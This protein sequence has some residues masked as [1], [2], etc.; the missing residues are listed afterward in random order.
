MDDPCCQDE[1]QFSRLCTVPPFSD[2]QCVSPVIVSFLREFRLSHLKKLV[3]Q[4]D[5]DPRDLEEWLPEGGGEG[6]H[7]D[8]ERIEA[9]EEVLSSLELCQG[10]PW[11]ER[12]MYWDKDE[13]RV[14]I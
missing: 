13:Y 14:Y 4:L 11:K 6:P 5:I 7:C 1:I 2:V 9:Y 8:K 3:G 12:S 10:E